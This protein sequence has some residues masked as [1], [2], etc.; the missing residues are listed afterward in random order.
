LVVEIEKTFDPEFIDNTLARQLTAPIQYRDI[1]AR[2][3]VRDT[4]GLTI[5]WERAGDDVHSYPNLADDR[6]GTDV[7]LARLCIRA[8]A[9]NTYFTCSYWK[10]R[11]RGIHA[12]LANATRYSGGCLYVNCVPSACELTYFV[13]SFWRNRCRGFHS[14]FTSSAGTLHL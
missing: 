2:P 3:G 11:Y 13:W 14:S 7:V 6:R 4:C 9:C 1:C 10:N 12:R 8:G 5:M